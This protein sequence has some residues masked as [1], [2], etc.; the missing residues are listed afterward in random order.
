[1]RG[2][3]A[4]KQVERTREE[5]MEFLGMTRKKKTVEDERNDP[6]KKM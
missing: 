1:M 4:R 6:V 5:E 2:I 3:L